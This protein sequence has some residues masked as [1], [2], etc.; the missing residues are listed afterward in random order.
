M[1]VSQEKKFQRR[2]EDFL[3]EQCGFSVSGDGYTNHC[4]R[5]LWSKHVDIAPGDRL[6][7]C[8]GLMEPVSITQAGKGYLLVHRCVT[9]GYQKKNR[10]AE[11]DDFEA[12]LELS[13]RLAQI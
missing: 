8:Q 12:V 1:I 4:P 10:S 5:C 7:E 2:K 11:Q 6:A 9:C 3:C 13:R